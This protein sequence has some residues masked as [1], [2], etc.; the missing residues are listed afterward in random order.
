MLAGTASFSAILDL[1]L[2]Q[3]F[4]LTAQFGGLGMQP[5]PVK[6]G[7]QGITNTSPLFSIRHAYAAQPLIVGREFAVLPLV[8][9]ETHMAAIFLRA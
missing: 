6:Q 5:N 9:T 8:E 3:S 1:C 7:R 2:A 4:R